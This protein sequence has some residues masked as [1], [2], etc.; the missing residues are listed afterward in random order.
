MVES[1][2]YSATR[3]GGE[4]LLTVRRHLIHFVREVIPDGQ[5]AGM[6]GHRPVP[7]VD[8]FEFTMPV[9]Q[10]RALLDDLATAVD[11]NRRR[12]S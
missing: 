7:S 2:E 12:S 6:T 9:D 5:M 3:A 11:G 8:E 10:A 1:I 4:V